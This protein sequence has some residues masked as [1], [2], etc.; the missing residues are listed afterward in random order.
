MIDNV[1]EYNEKLFQEY[2]SNPYNVNIFE[3]YICSELMTPIED[4]INVFNVLRKNY[5]CCINSTLLIVGA[6]CI[7]SWSS[8]ENEMLEILNK[9]YPYLPEKE[10]A[11]VLY[12]NA[13]HLQ[14]RYKE[15][16]VLPSYRKYL[17]ESIEKPVPFVF[18]RIDLSRLC[19]RDEGRELV[20]DAISNVV[21]V[22][23]DEEPVLDSLTLEDFINEHILGT[24]ISPI[25]YGL[26]QDDYNDL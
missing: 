14:C 7:S 25:V 22:F 24:H 12:L 1:F 17:L 2:N 15:Y 8:E 21:H 26:L 13:Y 18:N 9:M 4:F 23:G 3:K 19:K 10:Q 6:W 16:E 20:K 11:I 5:K